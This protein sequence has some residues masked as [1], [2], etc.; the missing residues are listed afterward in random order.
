M[1]LTAP[2]SVQVTWPNNSHD[3]YLV[4]QSET[5]RVELSDSCQSWVEYIQVE[6]VDCDCDI[7]MPN[8][9]TPN[10]DGL[11][12]VFK[13]ITACDFLDYRLVIF[14]RWGMKIFETNELGA[15]FKG[16]FKGKRVPTGVYMY[17]FTYRTDRVDNRLTGFFQLLR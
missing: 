15:G 11:N 4:D 17:Q 14:N 13:P 9:F 7:T 5:V 1:R 2:D 3:V 16:N 6:R 12:E 8:V 10:G